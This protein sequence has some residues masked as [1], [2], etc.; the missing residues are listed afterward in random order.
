MSGTRQVRARVQA[1]LEQAAREGVW[2]TALQ[3]LGVATSTL[4]WLALL[5]VTLTLHLAGFRRLTVLTGRIGHLAAEPDSFLKARALGQVPPGRYF[6]VAPPGEVANETLLSYWSPHIPTVRGRTASWL[7]LAMSRWVLMR[8]DMSGYI[9]R[10]GASQMVYRINADWRGRPPLL[11][12]SEN[13]RVW[14]RARFAELGLP[15]GAWF[16]CVHV[17]EPGFSPADDAAHA[18][19]NGEPR[20]VRAAMEEIVRRGG[21][22][23]RMGDASMTPLE[24]MD[25]VIDYAHHPLRSARL[26]VMLCAQARFFLGNTSGL[27]LVSSVFG[28]PS[29]LANMIPLSI[30][31][32]LPADLNIAKLLR[33]P[34]SGRLLGFAEILDSPAG[35]FRYARLYADAGLETLENSPDEILELVREMLDRISGA[36][37]PAAEDEALQHRFMMLLRP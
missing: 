10:L 11:A 21:W 12:L 33:S 23:V 17:R 1:R 20:A 27:A 30:L 4:A 22:C 3:V 18:H 9:L 7:L 28:V 14:S 16:V 19:R 2:G 25:G 31:G 5:P 24:P 37:A 13:D 8:H 32:I 34:R 36:W 29:A 26:D 15:E 6:L 35:D